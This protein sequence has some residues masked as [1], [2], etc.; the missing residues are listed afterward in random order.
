LAME[1]RPCVRRNFTSTVFTEHELV[2]GSDNH[3]RVYD[4]IYTRIVFFPLFECDQT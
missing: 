3:R 1:A 2:Q 4:P